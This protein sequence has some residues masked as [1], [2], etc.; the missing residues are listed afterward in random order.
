[1]AI[2]ASKRQEVALRA[3]FCCE[4]C[5][6]QLK[7]SADSFS[8][9]HI[10]PLARGGHD[11]LSNLALSCQRCNNAKFVALESTDPL[12]GHVVPLFHPREQVWGDHF[13]WSHDFLHIYGMTPTGRATVEKL[14]LNR[15][16]VVSLRHVLRGVGEHPPIHD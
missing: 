15:S 12:T 11:E 9:E 5:Q 13:A 1:M 8:V 16:G 6:S 3:F 2:S 10:V 7:Y 4:Y 14:H